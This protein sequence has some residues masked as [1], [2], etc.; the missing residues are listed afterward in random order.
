MVIIMDDLGIE[1]TK[2]KM[3]RTKKAIL[4]LV[5]VLIIVVCGKYLAT[6]RI[7]KYGDAR[8]HMTPKQIEFLEDNSEFYNNF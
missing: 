4:A 5:G 8:D 2:P 6:G 7:L 1:E 3:N